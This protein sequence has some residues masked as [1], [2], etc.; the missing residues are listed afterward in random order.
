MGAEDFVKL[1]IR[2]RVDFAQAGISPH[3]ELL[4]IRG[5]AHCGLVNSHGIVTPDDIPGLTV[6]LP[7]PKALIAEL[8]EAEGFWEPLP[9][10]WRYAAWDK[11]QSELE[12]VQAKRAKD[13][14]RK[15]LERAARRAEGTTT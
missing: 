6:R 10:G 7:R 12:A 3:A 1:S 8:V 2:Y 11:W 9:I 4:F 5:L 13:A 15:R 14:E